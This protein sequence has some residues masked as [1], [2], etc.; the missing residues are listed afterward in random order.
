[1]TK[2]KL[3][4]MTR[5][6]DI[7]Y[8]NEALPDFAGF[9][10]A[11]SRRQVTPERVEEMRKR[12]SDKVRAVGVFVNEK[13]ENIIALVNGGI[14]DVVQLHG[15]E[16]ENY[17]KELKSAVKCDIIKAVRVK[18]A[19]DILSAQSSAADY[20]LFDKFCADSYGGTGETFDHSLVKSE[21]PFFLAG[22]LSSENIEKAIRDTKPFAVDLSSGIETDGVKDREKIIDI[23]RRIRNV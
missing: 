12:L 20:L 10:F 1:M 9:V 17:I 19:E 16:D 8:I 6:C 5:D 18:T 7:D 11:K 23:V 3:C 2:I 15:D 22:G 21:K 14:I 4:G 13:A